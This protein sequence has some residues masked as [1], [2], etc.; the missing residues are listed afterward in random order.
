LRLP[1]QRERPILVTPGVARLLRYLQDADGYAAP[2]LL[3]AAIVDEI[4][5]RCAA[6]EFDQVGPVAPAKP[7]MRRDIVPGDRV[8]TVAG[9]VGELHALDASG[10]AML[11]MTW[12]NRQMP[13]RVKDARALELTAAGD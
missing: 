1:E 12:F 10:R 6:G 7:P 2:K 13:T 4:R 5:C 3:D 8:H 9:A 11:M